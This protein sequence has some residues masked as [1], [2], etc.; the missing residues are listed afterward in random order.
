MQANQYNVYTLQLNKFFKKGS[1]YLFK[2]LYYNILKCWEYWSLYYTDLQRLINLL[3]ISWLKNSNP[4]WIVHTF[5]PLFEALLGL[6]FLGIFD[7]TYA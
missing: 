7:N 1:K 5:Q 6:N 3:F 4:D 2:R